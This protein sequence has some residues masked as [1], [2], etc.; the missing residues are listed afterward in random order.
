MRELWNWVQG[1]R[2]STMIVG[3]LSAAKV[4]TDALGWHVISDQELNAIA[5]GAAALLTVITVVMSHVKPIAAASATNVG[6]T[7][8]AVEAS[9]QARDIGSTDTLGSA[10]SGGGHSAGSSGIDD[11]LLN[12]EMASDGYARP[13]K[14]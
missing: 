2:L 14:L 10:G 12:P 3:L 4:I 13:P 8:P 1:R 9:G 5:N 6:Q 11:A 7:G